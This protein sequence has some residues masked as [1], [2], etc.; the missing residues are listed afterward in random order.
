[1]YS[2]CLKSPFE[3]NL[4]TQ[5]EVLESLLE[6][7]SSRL[8]VNF[9]ASN[10]VLTEAPLNPAYC[11][12][13]VNELLFEKFEIDS[14]LTGIDALFAGH[15]FNPTAPDSLNLVFG[16]TTCH[17][18]P[19]LDGKLRVEGCQRLNVGGYDLACYFQRLLHLKNPLRTN[20]VTYSRSE[21]LLH[22]LCCVAPTTYGEVMKTWVKDNPAIQLAFP[23]RD[24]PAKPV[25]EVDIEA[26]KLQ[27]QQKREAQVSIQNCSQIHRR[28]R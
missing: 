20:Q 3:R 8:G 26:K 14:L 10:F 1:V 4:I 5:P 6:Y 7:G 12:S 28:S 11:R 18:L 19:V 22:N 15:F 2:G 13:T 23:L 9:Q 27:A 17:I 21:E 16:H 24:K 25:E